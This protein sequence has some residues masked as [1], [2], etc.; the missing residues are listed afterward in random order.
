MLAR[1]LLGTDLTDPVVAPGCIHHGAAFL[2]VVAE[3]FLAVDILAGHAGADKRDGVPVVGRADDHRV[4]VVPLENRVKVN[5]RRGLLAVLFLDLVSGPVHV[6][7]V[8]V[9]KSS[10]RD[11]RR[12]HE[13]VQVVATLAAAADE[14]NPN[15][16]AGGDRLTP[17]GSDRRM[18]CR[19]GG[20]SGGRRGQEP[21][22]FDEVSPIQL[23]PHGVL[24]GSHVPRDPGRKKRASLSPR[25]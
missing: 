19:P 12:T 8:H 25:F 15:G 1:P 11:L 18:E 24:L 21:G 16:L 5:G 17:S 20:D 14:R 2:D 10:D 23:I 22:V 9:A 13:D 7:L 6:P 3:R 4:H